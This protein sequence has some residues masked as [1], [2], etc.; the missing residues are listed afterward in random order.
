MKR[1][2]RPSEMA[3]AALFLLDERSSSYM[4]ARVLVLDGG[5]SISGLLG[6]D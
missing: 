4:T 6:S 5:F 2:G 3:G 1:Y